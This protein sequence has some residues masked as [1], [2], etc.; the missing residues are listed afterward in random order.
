[1]FYGK[2]C[3][4]WSCIVAWIYE[5]MSSFFKK[6]EASRLQLKV[7]MPWFLFDICAEVT[8]Q[9]IS[10]LDIHHRIFSHQIRW[11]L[12]STVWKI[13]TYDIWV[14]LSEFE[15]FF[16][17]ITYLDI[18][19]KEIVLF[20]WVLVLEIYIHFS[21]RCKQKFPFFCPVWSFSSWKISRMHC[22]KLG[23]NR[24]IWDTDTQQ[25]IHIS[26]TIYPILCYQY[27]SIFPSKKCLKTYIK[28]KP[29]NIFD[30]RMIVL[31]LKY[32]KYKPKLGVKIFRRG[33]DICFRT[34]LFEYLSNYSA[35]TCFSN[36]SSNPHYRD[37]MLRSIASRAKSKP[38]IQ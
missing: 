8:S 6:W 31:Y 1:M 37:V 10:K 18:T 34:K 35:A 26:R 16:W 15:V 36:T 11:N 29:K 25:F 30:T 5:Y 17:F 9:I 27:V 19:C 38:A 2:L 28:R 21:A 22:I 33:V 13:H 12:F 32:R 24:N 7:K 20:N 14:M 23:E 4:F 3:T